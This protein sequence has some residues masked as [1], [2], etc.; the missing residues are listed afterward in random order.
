MKATGIVRR[1]DDLGRIVI[2]KEIRRALKIN[3]GDPLELYYDA[4]GVLFK[5]YEAFS[6][7]DWETAKKLV[8][9]ILGCD[10]VLLNRWTDPKA[11]CVDSPM[12][13]DFL[14]DKDIKEI[15][16]DGEVVCYLVTGKDCGDEF[17]KITA[18]KI[19][20]TYIASIY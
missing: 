15:K 12:N 4:G 14:D 6:N 2:P 1:I 16:V 3:E 11:I 20:Q 7:A 19:I 10:F 5:K 17:D 18:Q 9:H 13:F 8:S